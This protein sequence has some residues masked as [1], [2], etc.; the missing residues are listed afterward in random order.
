M[1]I[2]EWLTIST[3]KHQFQK[4]TIAVILYKCSIASKHR[5]IKLKFI[6]ASSSEM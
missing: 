5:G 4:E 2:F 6:H 1:N 3:D